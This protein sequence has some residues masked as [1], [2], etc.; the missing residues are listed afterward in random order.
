MSHIIA[1]MAADSFVTL[2]TD[3]LYF[4]EYYMRLCGTCNRERA[5]YQQHESSCFVLRFLL[6]QMPLLSF[7]SSVIYL[8]FMTGLLK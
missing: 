7:V 2:G 1:I 5:P 4:L 6:S 3:Y 8:L